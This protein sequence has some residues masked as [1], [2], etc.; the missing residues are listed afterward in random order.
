M[1][2]RGAS[3]VVWQVLAPLKKKRDEVKAKIEKEVVAAKKSKKP[4]PKPAP[5]PEL[6]PM[7]AEIAK[8]KEAYD[9]AC[10]EATFKLKQAKAAHALLAAQQAPLL[11]LDDD[12]LQAAIG[13]AEG[14]KVDDAQ[15]RAGKEKLAQSLQAKQEDRTAKATA[16]LHALSKPPPLEVDKDAL[17]AAIETGG[18]ELVDVFVVD[19]AKQ[20]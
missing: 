19:A 17:G 9:G 12:A 6:P 11:E 10:K 18:K 3:R 1:R 13:A 20:A 4:A 16:A 8:N 15:V 7:S 2:A 5:A 14:A